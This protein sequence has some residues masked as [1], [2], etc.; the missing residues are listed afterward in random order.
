MWKRSSRGRLRFRARLPSN[1][2]FSSIV[3]MKPELSVPLRGRSGHDSTLTERVSKPS[4]GQASPHIF[5]DTFCPAKHNTSCR[6]YLSNMHFVRDFPQNPTVED[7]RKRS[8][9]ARL[10]SKSEGGRCKSEALM[11]DFLQIPTVQGVKTQLSCENSLKIWKWK[12]WNRS[13]RAFCAR[14]PSKSEVEDVKPKL[15]CE[16]SFKIRELKM[17]KRSFRERLPSKS[18]SWR[19]ENEAFV[20]DVPQNRTVEG[21]RKKAKLSCETSLEIWRWKMWKR[22]SHARLPSNSN[23]SRC[24]NAAFVREFPQNLKVEDVKP[25]LSCVLCE[26]SFKIWRWKPKLSCETSF[27]IRELKMWK[28]SFRARISSKSD[29]WRCE[30]EAFVRDFLQ[31]LKVEDVKPKLSCETSRKKWKWKMW[32]RSFSARLPWNF[33]VEDVKTQLSCET[34]FQKWKWKM[35]KQSFRARLPSK[36]ECWRCENEA[37]VRDFPQNLK[38]EAFVPCHVIPFHSNPFHSSPF[39]SIPFQSIRI[40]SIPSWPSYP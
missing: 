15:S 40:H 5:R 6:R 34:S 22:S 18:D 3:K 16:T 39:H 26:A 30:N 1:F 32:K 8:F 17:W 36:S 25:Q 14:L 23:S 2:Q 9:R 27:K 7:V 37:F 21:V 20:R 4:A 10:P 31:N 29:S 35:W 19:C 11:R 38:L 13:F 33:K 12:M 24:D 28:R